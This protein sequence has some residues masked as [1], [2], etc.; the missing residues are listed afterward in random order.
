MQAPISRA[1]ASLLKTQVHCLKA[2]AREIGAYML[3]GG[4]AWAGGKIARPV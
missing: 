1:S 4:R 3:A 2:L